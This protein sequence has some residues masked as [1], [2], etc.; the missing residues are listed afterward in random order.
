MVVGNGMVSAKLCE[1]LVALQLHEKLD[2]SV[3][4][5]EP[6]T[7]YNRVRLSDYVTTRSHT[8]LELLSSNW[9][10]DHNIKLHTGTSVTKVSREEQIITLSSGEEASYDLL[11]FATGSRPLVPPIRGSDHPSVFCYRT[12]SDLEEIITKTEGESS[13]VIIGG[14]LLGI[15]AA[16]AIQKLGL[17]ATII[18][19]AN[20]LM[21]QQL[22]QEAG[23]LLKREITQQKIAVHT[24]IQNTEI[25][26]QPGSLQLALDQEIELQADLVLISAGIQPNSELAEE[27]NLP[28]GVRG[29]IVVNDD[30][31][32]EDPS[33]FALGE[34]AL[35]HGRT[36]GLVAPGNL[37]ARHLALRL[38]GKKIYSLAPLDTSTRLKMLGVDVITI[39]EPLQ[40]GR[41]LEFISDDCY[42]SLNIGPKKRLIGALAVGNW[43]ESGRLQQLIAGQKSISAKQEKY[44]LQEGLLFPGQEISDPT[45]WPKTQIVCNC[46]TTNKETILACMTACQNDPDRICSATGAGSVCGSCRPLVEQLCGLTP[47][48]TTQ[49]K[50]GV[51]G[52]LAA[53]IIALALTAYTIIGPPA[54]MADSVESFSYKIDQLWRD[55]LIK[56]ISGYSLTAIFTIGLLISLRKRLPWFTWGKFAN[57][58][59]FHALFGLISLAALWA[60]TGFHFGANL[61]WWL[62]FVFVALNL[63][64]AIAGIVAAIEAKGTSETMRRLRPI[65]TKAHLI[66]FWPLPILLTFHILSVYLY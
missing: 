58:R 37:M 30:L 60:H 38:A 48:S 34:C 19:R 66:L 53:S 39:G 32:T 56:Q 10:H 29:G 47:Q 11:V 35:L 3:Y 12:I 2:I 54:T 13:A 41:R 25:H 45:K 65:L 26:H 18:E 21:P 23:T 44:F 50:V 8:A 5:E 46:T 59:F 14:G 40:E 17:K 24:G 62:M 42:R 43:H 28:V 51:I 55:N 49:N 63:L 52:L 22:T 61:N 6:F 1:E 9:Y 4:G 57:W 64:G 33:I 36:Y 20:F 31:E 15:E 16:Q 7:A 27:A